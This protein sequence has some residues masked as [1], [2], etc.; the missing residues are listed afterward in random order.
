MADTTELAAPPTQIAAAEC[1]LIPTAAA[2]IGTTPKALQRKI[3]R[4]ILPERIVWFKA[5]D[6]RVYID[7]RA[8]AKWVRGELNRGT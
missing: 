3:E 5:P 1:C 7:M 4:G 8:H 2:S 6:G